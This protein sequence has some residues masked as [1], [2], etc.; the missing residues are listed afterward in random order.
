MEGVTLAKV[1]L[2]KKLP[3]SLK[4]LDLACGTGIVAEELKKQGYNDIDGLDPVEGYITTAQAKHLYKVMGRFRNY[5]TKFKV[6]F[7]RKYIESL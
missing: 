6:I 1:F 4:I 5:L 2:A 7:F 3:T